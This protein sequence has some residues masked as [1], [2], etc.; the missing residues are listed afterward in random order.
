MNFFLP[1]QPKS[2]FWNAKQRED[3]ALQ[4]S[5]LDVEGLHD[6]AV[7]YEL[8]ALGEAEVTQD[9]FGWGAR[10]GAARDKAEVR[11][12]SRASWQ[13]VVRAR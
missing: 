13:G 3:L 8:V 1:W 6:L 9:L 11:Q 4:L 2:V 10:S 12:C 5:E 7:L